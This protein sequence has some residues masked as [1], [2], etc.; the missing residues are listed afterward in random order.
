MGTAGS[1]GPS[2]NFFG[3][4][5]QAHT[6]S[7]IAYHLKRY[8]HAGSLVF[9]FLIEGKKPCPESKQAHH[10]QEAYASPRQESPGG[11]VSS[12]WGWGKQWERRSWGCLGSV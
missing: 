3:L 10:I 1:R 7:Q 8:W 9:F 4:R 5:H 6:V 2:G 12:G 11:G